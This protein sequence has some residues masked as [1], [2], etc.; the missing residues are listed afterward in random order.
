MSTL[1]LPLLLL[2][3]GLFLLVA[4]VFVP[5]GGLI[6]FL[7]VCCLGMSLWRAFQVSFDL[8][9]KFLLADCVLLPLAI[10]LAIHLWPRMPLAKR[11][12]LSRPL[13]EE[14]DISHSSQRL[15][16][17]VGQLGRALTPLRPSG[18]VDFDGR[19][20]DGLS[21][22]GLIPAG[23]L[24]LAVRVRSGQL[25]VRPAP[26]PQLKELMSEPDRSPLREDRA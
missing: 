23:A 19:R 25:V 7:A 18:L 4:E 14:I 9:V 3:I 11:V 1:A 20:L 8:G 22:E 2:A 12:F 21:E 16:H 13:P 26:D 15:D 10:G 24:I 17:L 5:S 6:G